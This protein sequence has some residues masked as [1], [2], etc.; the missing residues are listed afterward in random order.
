VAGVLFVLGS[1]VTTAAGGRAV[2]VPVLLAGMLALAV[3]FSPAIASSASLAI[4]VMLC[5][6]TLARSV[7]WTVSYPLAATGA[8]RSGA[9]V[10]M[11]MGLLNGVWAVTVL[12]SPLCAAFVAGYLSPRA[13]FGLTAAACLALLAV[14]AVTVRP[15]RD[16]GSWA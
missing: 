7:L 2:R 16:A 12:L 5:T 15:R 4:V 1:A 6:T 3:A 14:T 10:G 8:E 13:V 9:G 11:V